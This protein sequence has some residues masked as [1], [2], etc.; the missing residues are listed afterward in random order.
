MKNLIFSLVFIILLISCD[1]TKEVEIDLPDPDPL[2]VVECY[3]EPGARY[4]LLLTKNQAYFDEFAETPEEF[5]EDYLVSG[6][7][8][9][10]YRDEEAIPLQNQLV[11]DGNDKVFNYF[12]FERV[13]YDTIS[14]FRLEIVLNNG[15]II[16]SQTKILPIV[17]IDSSV[18]EFQDPNEV[19]MD[20]IPEARVLTYVS[21]NPNQE[22]YYRRMYH[23]NSLD[24]IP[25]QDFLTGDDF[26]DSGQLVF[27][28]GFFYRPGDTVFNAI[29]HMSKE[30][31]DYQNS[32]FNSIAASLN[33]FATPGLIESNVQS[34]GDDAIGIFAGLSLYREM[35]LFD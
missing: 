33:P 21:D 4:Q 19:P 2:T 7:T 28:T 13:P 35:I 32:I 22:N 12:S 23:F 16:T 17:A 6:A 31:Y 8:V 1:L 20:S 26:V 24:S 11:I 15:D 5:L 9:T 18:V 3:L 10:I 25:E 29:I 14:N 27:G 30:Y 34:S